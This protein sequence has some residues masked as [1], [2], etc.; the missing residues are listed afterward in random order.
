MESL[1]VRLI[2]R[3]PF[4]EER[5]PRSIASKT[6]AK[7]LTL[8]PQVGALPEAGDYWSMFDFNL[9]TIAEAL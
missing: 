7:V 9:K 8:A 6:G 4:Y 2:I 5:T 3:S 1:G